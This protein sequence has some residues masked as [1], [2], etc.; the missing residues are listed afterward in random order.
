MRA[1]FWILALAALGV[2]LSSAMRLADGYVLWV[3]PPW[4]V[5]MSFNLFVALL[6]ATIVVLFLFVRAIS[7][8][9]GLPRRVAAFR[10]RRARRQA[11][12]AAI[13]ALRLLWEGRFSAAVKRAETAFAKIGAG[14]TADDAFAEK[15]A[16]LAAHTALKAAHALR[17]PVRSELWQAR[18]EGFDAAGWKSARVI[19]AAREALDAHDLVAARAWLAQLSAAE[20]RRIAVLRLALRIAAESGEWRE[21]LEL[22]RLLEKHHALTPEQAAPLRI[23][24]ARA[25]IDAAPP[26]AGRLLDL[27][28]RFDAR[29]R[30]DVRLVDRLARKLAAAGACAEAAEIV[31][32]FLEAQWAPELLEAYGECPGGDLM[33]RIAHAEQWLA[34]HPRDGRLLLLLGRLCLARELWGK[35]KS[36]LEASLAIEESRAAHLELARLAERLGEN[37]A[38]NRHYRAAALL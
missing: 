38:A 33:R 18:A 15:I 19:D 37:E 16:A 35:A 20:R 31:E 11:Y 21:V 8:L 10:R 13:E 30:D 25:L 7:T 1:L 36:Y 32:S 27:W 12:E 29:E 24:A 14:E 2:G 34:A 5:E 23:K 4:R 28:R 17:D 9:V 22:V 26:E 3:L 6:L